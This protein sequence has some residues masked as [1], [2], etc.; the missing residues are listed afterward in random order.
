MHSNMQ[1]E[2]KVIEFGESSTTA[3]AAMSFQTHSLQCPQKSGI[4]IFLI[5]KVKMPENL[6]NG[7]KN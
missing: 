4:G 3:K 5:P 1:R 6:H 7:L 2:N